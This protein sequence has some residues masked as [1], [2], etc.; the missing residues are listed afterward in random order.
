M[1][2]YILL[3]HGENI[4][5]VATGRACV[6]VGGGSSEAPKVSRYAR[7]RENTPY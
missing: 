4:S 2:L 7:F 6:A 3:F 1:I 5:S